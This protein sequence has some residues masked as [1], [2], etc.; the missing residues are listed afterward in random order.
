[1][2]TKSYGARLSIRDLGSGGAWTDVPVSSPSSIVASN[3][4]CRTVGPGSNPGVGMDVCKCNVP[5]WHWGT[6]NS[7]RVNTPL[8]RSVEGEERWDSYDQPQSVLPQNWGGTEQNHTVTCR[9][10][11]AKANDRRKALALSRNEFRGFR[12]DVTVNQIGS[13][14][15]IASLSVKSWNNPCVVD[16]DAIR[17]KFPVL[18][19]THPKKYTHDSSSYV[20][21]NNGIYLFPLKLGA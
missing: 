21:S 4:D 10:L 3:A 9:V 13:P 15:S 14:S 12:S 17:K 16:W 19:K 2:R 20:K 5:L 18:L 11:K 7:L 6:L 1:M 8:V